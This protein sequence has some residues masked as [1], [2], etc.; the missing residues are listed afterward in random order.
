MQGI[1]SLVTR[2]GGDLYRGIFA[3][4]ATARGAGSVPVKDSRVANPPG[5]ATLRAHLDDSA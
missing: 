2:C 4:A 3:I 1:A 5:L